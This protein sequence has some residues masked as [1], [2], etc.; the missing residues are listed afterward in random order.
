[1]DKVFPWGHLQLKKGDQ[2]QYIVIVSITQN[3]LKPQ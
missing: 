3:V 2:P 1:M